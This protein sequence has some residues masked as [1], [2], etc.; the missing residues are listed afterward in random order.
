MLNK[1]HE[2]PSRSET[3]ALADAERKNAVRGDRDQSKDLGDC[4][5]S[6]FQEMDH[7]D[8]KLKVSAQSV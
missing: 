7:A 2:M 4:G 5:Q 8:S 3:A 6:G 1:G